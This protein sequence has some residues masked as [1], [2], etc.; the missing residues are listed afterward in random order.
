V[1][2]RVVQPAQLA[3]CADLLARCCARR[4]CINGYYNILVNDAT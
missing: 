4:A 2:G 1:V 3:A